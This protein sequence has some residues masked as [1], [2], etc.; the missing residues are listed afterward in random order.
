MKKST[1]SRLD[2]SLGE[3]G[4]GGAGGILD[5]ILGGSKP[6]ATPPTPQAGAQSAGGSLGDM[7]SSMLGDSKTMKIGGLGA[8][9]GVLLGGGTKAVKGGLGG[10]ALALLGSL[11]LKAFRGA[12]GQPKEPLQLDAETKLAA[13]LRAPENE[14]E[15][16]Q[17]QAFAELLVKAMVNAAKADGRID[18]GELKRITGNLEKDGISA[19]EQELLDAELRGPMDTD[20]LV[21]AVPSPQVAAQV[22]AA[23]LLAVELDTDAEKKYLAELAGKL[24]LDANVV[25]HLHSAVGVA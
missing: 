24:G 11:A 10:G 14:R 9:A 2:H 23:S 22:Y 20:G 3:G 5:Q 25:R 16:N 18:E 8:L 12:S 7:V 15:L 1:V 21:R 6:S 4:V 13:G 17:V 19:R